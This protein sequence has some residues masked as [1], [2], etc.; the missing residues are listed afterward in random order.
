MERRSLCRPRSVSALNEVYVTQLAAVIRSARSLYELI[1]GHLVL[2]TCSL[3]VEG[4]AVVSVIV[5]L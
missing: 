2:C 5:K 4:G 3:K 1:S